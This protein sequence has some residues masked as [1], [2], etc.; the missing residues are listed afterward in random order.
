MPTRCETDW[1]LRREKIQD[2]T[3]SNLSR[4]LKFCPQVPGPYIVPARSSC[5]LLVD[6]W[7]AELVPAQP[8]VTKDQVGHP[9]SVLCYWR[10]N[11]ANPSF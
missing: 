10:K 7:T 5:W 4:G 11:T 3:L 6:I 1:P 2:K 9:P 8:G